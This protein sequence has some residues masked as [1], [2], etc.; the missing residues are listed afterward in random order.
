MRSER[1]DM[2]AQMAH[3][4][5]EHELIETEKAELAMRFDKATAEKN[6]RAI[7]RR[8]LHKHDNRLIHA[9]ARA[10]LFHQAAWPPS[11]N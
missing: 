2:L 4:L 3:F 1:L 6:K 7:L 11:D 9:F 10:I 5:L 8:W